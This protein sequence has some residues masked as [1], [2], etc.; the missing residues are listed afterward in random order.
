MT[1]ISG[2]KSIQWNVSRV[3]LLLGALAAG[4]YALLGVQ[5]TLVPTGEG[6]RNLSGHVL[7]NDFLFFFTASKL[8]LAG[9]HL[10]VF[11]QPRFFEI[12]T[13]IS[14][15]NIKFPWAYPPHFLLFVAP[16]ALLSYVPAMCLWIVGTLAPFIVLIRRYAGLS[17]LAIPVLPPLVQNAIS[18]QNGAL[19][20][21]LVTG[22]IA[23]LA[24]Q[25][26]LLAGLLFGCLAYKPQVFVLAPI[27]L[28]A[29][30]DP[31]ALIGLAITGI[32]LPLLGLIF[33]GADMWRLFFLHLP[34]Q[35]SYV[36]SGRMPRERFATV[37]IGLLDLTE[38]ANLALAGQAISMLAAWALV[39]WCWRR[40]SDVFV[41]AFA[42]S[43]A[44]P[45]STPY[46]FEYDY[47]LW[48]LPAAILAMRV[49]SGQ[50]CWRNWIPLII[51]ALL[52]PFI[53]YV[54]NFGYNLS[55]G[56]TLMLAPF[57]VA[58]ARRA[59]SVERLAIPQP[60]VR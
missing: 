9:E 29:C 16:L 11:D 24:S 44:M 18:G 32:G 57:L 38:N 23:A 26:S 48:S 39:Y 35:M 21:S 15:R 34:D 33:F 46:L 2:S 41:R 31:R 7:G 54:S 8:A 30:R 37:F 40:S 36:V 1:T 19:T 51:L 58:E 55:V 3:V 4:F 42:F 27:C 10:T 59:P 52:P 20:A 28:L 47:A 45:L 56:F 50:G 14:G 43:V 22:G 12:Q 5:Y 53:W 60:L 49:W 25:R 13:A 6:L 17:W